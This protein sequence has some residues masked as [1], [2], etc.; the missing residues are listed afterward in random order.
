MV[1]F[2]LSITEWEKDQ[3]AARSQRGRFRRGGTGSKPP[4]CSGVH[5]TSRI[6]AR[7]TPASAP[8]VRIASAA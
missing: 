3:V 2:F 4:G 7:T 6:A 1:V 8:W 5:F